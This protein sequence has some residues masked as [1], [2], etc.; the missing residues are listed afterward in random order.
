[1]NME[2]CAPKIPLALTTPSV[3]CGVG[4][5][6]DERRKLGVTGQLP[7]GVLTLEQ[8]AARVWRQ[9]QSTPTDLARNVLLD[10]LHSRHEILYFKVLAEHLT[11]LMP[12]VYTPTVGEAI[13][14][15]SEEYRGQRDLRAVSA[16]VAEAVYH[17]AVDDGVATK[18]H[19]DVV[20]TILDAMWVPEYK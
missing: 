5:T 13:Q 1:M 7:S 19:D 4:F 2:R 6:H 14:R 9:L 8:Q 11:E 15:F 18:K 3:N 12:V 17:A 20:Q 16:T 10:Q